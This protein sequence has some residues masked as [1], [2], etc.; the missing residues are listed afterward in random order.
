MNSKCVTNLM[1]HNIYS[2]PPPPIPECMA[3]EVYD[4]SVVLQWRSP[5][6]CG[7]RTD[8]YYQIRINDGPALQYNPTRFTF[9]AQVTY[10]VNNLQQDTTYS[11]TVSIHNGVSDQDANN[12]KLRE[13]PVV[14]T[15][16]QGS[17][18]DQCT[19]CKNSI[20]MH[21]CI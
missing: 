18:F 7:G 5:P 15:T 19:P 13:C 12:A 8:C 9:N 3:S 6:H 2:A 20:H 14:V 10:A 17:M 4:T 21:A 11:I 1:M 16:I